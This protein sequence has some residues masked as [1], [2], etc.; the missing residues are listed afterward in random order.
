MRHY[1]T[2]EMVKIPPFIVKP[3]TD[4]PVS[5]RQ[6]FVSRRFRNPLFVERIGGT[7]A[8]NSQM[9]VEISL[10]ELFTSIVPDDELPP[11]N[12]FLSGGGQQA[13][14]TDD[15]ES[16]LLQ[17]DVQQWT[18]NGARLAFSINNTDS[19]NTQPVFARVE[20]WQREG[21]LG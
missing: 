4:I 13:F 18:M 14:L 15:G 12:N 2:D 1:L 20:I 9:L 10:F 3:A 17:F 5:T 8:V 16:G 19:L 7:V 6:T 21:L 11:G